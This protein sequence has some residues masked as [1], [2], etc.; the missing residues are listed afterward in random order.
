VNRAQSE[1]LGYVLVFSLVLATVGTVYV[2]GVTELDDSRAD[3]QVRNVERAFDVLADNL[4]DIHRHG[5]PRRATELQLNEG[6]LSFGDVATVE[7]NASAVA[8]RSNFVHPPPVNVTP[9]TY[10]VGETTVAY[11]T[12][13]V[14]RSSPNGVTTHSA[15]GW[16]V[17]DDVVAI[18]LVVTSAEVRDQAV[19]GPGTVLLATDAG[20]RTV[21]VQFDP[22]GSAVDLNVTVTSPRWSAWERHFGPRADAVSTDAANGSVTF[23]FRTDRVIV[24]RT[25]VSVTIR[26]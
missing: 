12:G 18:P 23:R 10:T 11:S 8:N 26:P 24:T 16:V 15:P 9:V 14:F 3:A 22:A 6:S 17:S 1:T 5:A 21:P 7:V 25:S 20:G 13:G 4:R 2:A 19:G